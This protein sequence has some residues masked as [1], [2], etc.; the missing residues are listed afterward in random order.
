MS[1][2]NWLNQLAFISGKVYLGENRQMVR[3]PQPVPL[4]GQYAVFHDNHIVAGKDVIDL[5]LRLQW[6]EGI[7]RG[8]RTEI[9]VEA[10]MSGILYTRP[11]ACQNSVGLRILNRIE[12]AGDD[13]RYLARQYAHLFQQYPDSLFSRGRFR[14]RSGC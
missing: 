7:K 8:G 9:G 1:W 5:A 2:A 11:P 13:E 10:G 4:I 6:T 14:D 3:G 12:I